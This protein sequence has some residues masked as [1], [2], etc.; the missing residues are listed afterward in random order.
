MSTI[1]DYYDLSRIRPE[2][3]VVLTRLNQR[4]EKVRDLIDVDDRLRI[5]SWQAEFRTLEQAKTTKEVINN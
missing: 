1:A 4:Y 5:R 3:Q 2:V